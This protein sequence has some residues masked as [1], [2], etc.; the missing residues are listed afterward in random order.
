MD[1]S[2]I[3]RLISNESLLFFPAIKDNISINEKN[4]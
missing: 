4:I 1:R 3:I 2:E